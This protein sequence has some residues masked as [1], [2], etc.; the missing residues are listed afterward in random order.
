MASKVFRFILKLWWKNGKFVDLFVSFGGR[1]A[2][3]LASYEVR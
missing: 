2:I 1:G 3:L